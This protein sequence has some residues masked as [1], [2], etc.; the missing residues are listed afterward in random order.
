MNIKKIGMTALAASL[1]STSVFA[2]ELTATGT[3]SITVENYSGEQVNT[4]KGFSMADS[5]TL[6]G[7]TELDNGMTVSMSFELD[8]ADGDVSGSYD[9]HSVTISSDALGTFVFSGNG[10]S[11]AVSALDATAAGDIF[12]NFDGQVVAAETT[13]AAGDA[14]VLSTAGGNNTMLYTLPSIVD[15]LSV[16]ASYT[17]QGAT[18]ESSSAYG[19]TYTGVDGL[20]VSYGSGTNDAGVDAFKADVTT[21]KASYAY[22]PITVA[23]SDHEFDSATATRDQ[24]TTSYSIAYT[25][26]DSI[27]ISYGTEEIDSGEQTVDAEYSKISASYTSGGMTI[28]ATSQEAEN[29]SYTTATTEDQDYWG[30]TL[31]FAF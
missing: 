8:A 6:T 14:A 12:D 21:M 25:V 16:S 27:S 5:V 24:D 13:I 23:Y 18:T 9:D 4:G 29:I 7:S 28:T 10:G 19:A 26:S 3:A 31:G 22:G 30:L 11:T 20:S 15:G 17:P 2:G 1:V